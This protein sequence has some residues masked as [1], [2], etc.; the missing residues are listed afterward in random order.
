[1][2]V[3]DALQDGQLHVYVQSSS[4]E[5]M[6]TAH[7]SQRAS[8]MHPSTCSILAGLPHATVCA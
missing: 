7:V 2:A 8:C 4:S 3:E 6:G 1:M 5:T